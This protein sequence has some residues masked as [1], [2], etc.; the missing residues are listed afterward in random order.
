MRVEVVASPA[1]ASRH[2]LRRRST[3][4]AGA[5]AHPRRWVRRALPRESRSTGA[6]AAAGCGIALRGPALILDA[7]GTIALDA[8]FAAALGA[9]RR[10]MLV[11]RG[12]RGGRSTEPATPRSTRCASKSS[13]TCSCRSPSR[14]AT[15]CA[16]TAVSTNIRERLDFSCAVFDAGGGLV[17]NA[18]HIPVHLGAMGESIRGV[19]AA[20][21][22]SAPGD[23]FATNDPAAAA[24]TCPTSPW[25]RRCT[26]ATARCVFFTASRGHHADVGGITPGSM[27][28]FSRRLAEEGV[29]LRAV[30]MVAA[31]ASTRTAV[32]A[33]CCRAG[34]IRRAAADNLADLQAQIAANQRGARLLSHMLCDE[35]GADLVLAYM[36]HV[37]DNAAAQVAREIAA[38]PDGEHRF[39]DALDDGTPIEVCVRGRRRPHR[40]RLH[41]HR[42]RRSPA[43]STRRARSP[44]LPCSTSC[45]V[46]SARASRSTAA[47]CA[48][49]TLVIPAGKSA[50]PGPGRRGGGGNVETSQR[51]VDVLLGRAGRSPRQPGHDEQPHLR[52][53]DLRLLRDDCRRRRR[54]AQRS[55]APS[56]CTPT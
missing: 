52:R 17:A 3:G 9:A 22:R 51:V 5:A 23:V 24:R 25:S 45:A 35:R 34:R 55:A 37:Q 6:R 19:L 39:A 20:H 38:L 10:L 54:H 12:G 50:E 31:A 42:R 47:A 49:L 8:G 43:T 44:S 28:P 36:G 14:W 11:D 18:P 1:D 29:V 41:R 15:P 27:P 26:T 53:R 32:R 46:W 2:R 16:R 21:P 13:T 4:P 40:Y 56:A 7:T 30:P 48:R 33:R